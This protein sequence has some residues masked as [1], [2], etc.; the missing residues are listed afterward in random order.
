MKF[1]SF[2]L[3]VSIII[4]TILAFSCGGSSYTYDVYTPVYMSFDTLRSSVSVRK[5]GMPDLENPGKIYLI[6]N[7]LFVGERNAGIHVI[8]I[9]DTTSPQQLAFIEVPGN[10]D[11]AIL[12]KD[13]RTILYADSFIDLV[14]MELNADPLDFSADEISR[15]EGVFPN[16][17]YQYFIDDPAMPW[18]ADVDLD[19][20]VVVSYETETVTEWSEYGTESVDYAVEDSSGGTSGTGGSM[21][22]FTLYGNDSDLWHLYTVDDTN[23]RVFELSSPWS[24]SPEVSKNLGWDIETI[25]PYKNYLYIG[26]SS[27]MYLYSLENPSNPVETATVSHFSSR[28]PVVVGPVGPELPG[29]FSLQGSIPVY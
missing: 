4:L 6:G 5:A 25:F 19:D 10:S 2:P 3:L 12:E 13:N 11:L 18:F 27:A 1:K 9:E 14:V 23:L 29:T 22:R 7:L 28:D 26:S 15:L 20:Q 8:D 17:P 24:P 16:D 21:A